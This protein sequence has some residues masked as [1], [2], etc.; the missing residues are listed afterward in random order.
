M[1]TPMNADDAHAGWAKTRPSPGGRLFP[2]RLRRDFQSAEVADG[3]GADPE[4]YAAF[5][6]GSFFQIVDD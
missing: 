6:G 2:E 5:A 4:G 3:A 1:G